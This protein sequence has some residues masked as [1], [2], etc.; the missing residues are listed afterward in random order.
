MLTTFD[1]IQTFCESIHMWIDSTKMENRFT[2]ILFKKIWLDSK[3]VTQG[4]WTEG[5]LDMNQW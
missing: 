3:G 4:K 2:A 1:T 5:M